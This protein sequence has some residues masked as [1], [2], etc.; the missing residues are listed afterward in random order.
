MEKVS[1]KLIDFK[2]FRDNSFEINNLTIL[3]GANAAGKS[4]IIQAL[5]ILG[6]ALSS[7][8]KSNS[9]VNIS[10]QDEERGIELESADSII[11]VY[12]DSNA[13]IILD[14]NEFVCGPSDGFD[15]RNLHVERNETGSDD[16]HL[17]MVYLSAERTGP[18]FQ[19]KK[20]GSLTC[21]CHGEHTASII[22]SRVS[23]FFKIDNSRRRI[24]V[25]SNNFQI[26]LDAW[27]D[28]LFPG[29]SVKVIPSGVNMYQVRIRNSKVNSFAHSGGLPYC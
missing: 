17:S 7:G 27:L 25:E 21:G 19:V 26:Q 2:C 28:F 13:R 6:A 10:L 29:L 5:Q 4:S 16:I 8:L 3:T 18:R 15:A 9:S 12:S 11:N 1:L 23:S 14:G 24:G 22:D 20:T